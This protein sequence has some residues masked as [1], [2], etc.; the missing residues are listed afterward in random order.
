MPLPIKC[1][2]ILSNGLNEDHIKTFIYAVET[3]SK[4][5]N[6]CFC[7][8]DV[9]KRNFVYVSE[10]WEFWCGQ[11]SEVIM[12]MG[13]DF[14]KSYVP[15][16]EFDILKKAYNSA[17]FFLNSHQEDDILNTVGSFDFHIMN[18]KKKRL[19]N[20]HFIPISLK[21][22]KIHLIFSSVDWSARK[23]AEHFYLKMN[24][25]R[26]FLEFIP[27]S[28]KWESKPCILLTR[29][30]MDIL[31][32]SSRGY[33]IAEISSTINL[34]QDS[35]KQTRRALYQRLNVSNIAEAVAHTAIYR[36]I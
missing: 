15:E 25:E 9:L 30:E 17:L 16:E 1:R 18:R 22:G 33:S 10:G 13:F 12:D 3:F 23:S 4:V 5:S 35:V 6:K 34:S 2:D 32:L 19:T 8:I 20:H 36:M 24:G 7:L 29:R 28:N 14:Y 11:N 31:L 27:K 26:C 21:E